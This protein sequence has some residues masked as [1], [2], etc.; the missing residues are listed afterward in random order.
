LNKKK[1][2]KKIVFEEK[3]SEEINPKEEIFDEVK[4]KDLAEFLDWSTSM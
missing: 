4:T 1:K 3:D 2:K